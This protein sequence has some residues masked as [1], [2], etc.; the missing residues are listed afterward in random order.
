MRPCAT[1]RCCL[2]GGE[3]PAPLTLSWQGGEAEG[4]LP[5]KVP[6]WVG[7]ALTKPGRA[8]T[9]RWCG[10]GERDGKEYERNPRYYV[11]QVSTGLNLADLGRERCTN[12][13]GFFA[14]GTNSWAGMDALA[15]RPW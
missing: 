15:G 12:H 8:R 3:R 4:S 5:R 11:S 6:G 9:A 1:R 14:G 13:R 7:A 10:S 2:S